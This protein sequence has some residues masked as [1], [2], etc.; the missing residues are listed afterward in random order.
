MQYLCLISSPLR[1]SDLTKGIN[2]RSCVVLYVMVIAK[3]VVFSIALLINE[4]VWTP[5]VKLTMCLE[6][7]PVDLV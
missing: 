5:F 3:I 6:S 2:K 4:P 1:K 7:L